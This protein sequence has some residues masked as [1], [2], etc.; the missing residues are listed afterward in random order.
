MRA[1]LYTLLPIQT[2]A[3]SFDLLDRIL[4]LEFL[5]P[6]F[7]F[8]LRSLR[9]SSPLRS[10]IGLSINLLRTISDNSIHS[11]E[12]KPGDSRAPVEN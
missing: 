8:S 2:D 1:L 3:S 11:R 4:R 6:L 10:S 9:H 12:K 7:I 5:L